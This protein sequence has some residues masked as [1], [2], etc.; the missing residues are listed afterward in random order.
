MK[1]TPYLTLPTEKIWKKDS[2]VRD[3]MVKRKTDPVLIRI[4]NLVKDLNR[5]RDGGEIT[6]LYCE[7]FFASNYWIN[8][9][10]ATRSMNNKRERPVCMLRDFCEKQ[11][12]AAF[13]CGTQMVRAKLQQYYGTSVT[14]HG[15]WCDKDISYLPLARRQKFRLVFEHGRAY[16]LEWWK[17]SSA[18]ATQLKLVNT[19]FA[20]KQTMDT[21]TGDAVMDLNGLRDDWAFFVLSFDRDI[22][23]GP[24][25][26]GSASMTMPVFHSS[27]L[28]GVSV[29]FAGSIH[30]VEG[31]VL[32]VRNDSGHYQP[33]NNFFTN[34]LAQLKTVGVKLRNVVLYDFKNNQILDKDNKIYRADRY[35]LESG[36]WE[37]LATRRQ[38]YLI[39]RKT[40][41]TAIGRKK[42]YNRIYPKEDHTQQPDSQTLKNL[43]DLAQEQYNLSLNQGKRPG[44]ALW[45]ETWNGVCNAVISFMPTDDR[46]IAKYRKA[47]QNRAKNPGRPPL[48]KRSPA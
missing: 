12:A 17:A 48:P 41:A 11:L 45:K 44:Y 9:Y 33:N 8:N 4:D 43:N 37:L 34:I 47:W 42:I 23:I 25:K 24:H 1:N 31:V 39:D 13:Q 18:Q 46:A 36:R 29:Q 38:E 15:I 16:W 27:Y 40:L 6:Y 30:I 3:I 7:L 32:G 28:S 21:K 10:R 14:P 19:G 20:R 22:Y 2:A 26:A 35:L 5:A